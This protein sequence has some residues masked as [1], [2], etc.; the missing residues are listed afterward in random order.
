[1]KKLTM[2]LALLLCA[3][4][5]FPCAIA[6][7][8]YVPGAAINQMVNDAWNS[9]AMIRGDAKL[10]LDIDGAAL[11]LSSDEQQ[12]LDMLSPLLDSATLRLG[13]GKI[14]DGLRLELGAELAHAQGGSPVSVSAAANVDLYGISLESDLIAGQRVTAKWETLLAMAGMN[15]SDIEMLM[16]LRDLDWASIL[17]EFIGMAEEYVTMALDTLAPYGDTAYSW[18]MAL[19]FELQKHVVAHGYP[20][21]AQVATVTINEKDVGVLITQLANQL[22]ADTDLCAILDMLIQEGYTGAGEAPTTAQVCDELIAEAAQFTNT[23]DPLLLKIAV[24]EHLTPLYVQLIGT[25]DGVMEAYT[26]VVARKNTAGNYDYAFHFANR[27]RNGVATDSVTIS[28]E[29]GEDVLTV[30]C[31]V[32]EYGEQVMGLEYA[33]NSKAAEGFQPGL[34]ISQ[35]MNMVVEDSSETVQMVMNGN[36]DCTMM[37]DGGEVIDSTMTMDVYVGSESMT[38]TGLDTISLFPAEDGFTGV[39]GTNMSMPAAG[40]HAYGMDVM[41]STGRY[42]PATTAALSEISLETSSSEDM[43]ALLNVITNMGQLKLIAAIQALPTEL[44]NM[45]IS[46]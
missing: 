13:A 25:E 45:L 8:A 16:L 37:S 1:M 20:A 18:L 5:T 10:R 28:G 26:D 11:G 27:I 6:E 21:A 2:M 35:N 31:E 19:P 43:E 7:K 33:L 41:L 24:D 44:L 39:Y 12:I 30:H 14:E 42:D 3:L 17:P 32:Y 23:T 22:K 4:L 38:V 36:T 29:I 46:M 9:G 34:T 15:D 40:I